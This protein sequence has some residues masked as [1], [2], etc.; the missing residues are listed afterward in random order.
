VNGDLK[1]ELTDE[2]LVEL[3]SSQLSPKLAAVLRD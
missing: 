3:L 1:I 2:T